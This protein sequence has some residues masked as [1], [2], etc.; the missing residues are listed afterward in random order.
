MLDAAERLFYPRGVHEVGMDEL[1]RESELGKA[2]VYRLFAT[3][4]EL[5]GAYLGR[6]SERILAE[7]DAETETHEDPAGALRALYAAIERD[8]SRSGFRGC[9]FNNASIEFA[10]PAHPARRVAR[11]HRS[12]LRGRLRG[13]AAALGAED[14]EMLGDRL[15]LLIDG[16]YM[17]AAHLGADGP[18]VRGPGL[19]QALVDEAG[20]WTP[21]RA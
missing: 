8:V 15:A 20:R 17:S 19:A 16:M 4:D 5:I 9:A 18:A 6:L 3:K 12:Q 13:L 2:T 21:E 7:I 11:E 10:D 14:P 1:V